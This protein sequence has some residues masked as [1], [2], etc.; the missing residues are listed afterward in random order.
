MAR[1]ALITGLVLGL[2]ACSGDA[3]LRIQ[4]PKFITITCADAKGLAAPKDFVIGD[5]F[6]RV[7]CD[8]NICFPKAD[9]PMSDCLYGCDAVEK[10]AGFFSQCWGP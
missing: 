7:I 9:S 1:N 2:T 8:N 3:H 4:R 5:P 6:V 10:A